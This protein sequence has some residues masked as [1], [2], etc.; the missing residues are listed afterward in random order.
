MC[1]KRSGSKFDFIEKGNFTNLEDNKKNII[2]KENI[3]SNELFNYCDLTVIDPT[4]EGEI[5]KYFGDT[6]NYKLIH[7]I[8]PNFEKNKNRPGHLY[9]LTETNEYNGYHN[10]YP[11]I[12]FIDVHSFSYILN[13]EFLFMWRKNYYRYWKIRT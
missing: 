8:I 12:K 6:D 10:I 1:W 9:N 3:Y 4:K 13:S 11:S 7:Y 5:K 2:L